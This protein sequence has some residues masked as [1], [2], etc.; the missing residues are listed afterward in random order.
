MSQSTQHTSFFAVATRPV[1][2][3]LVVVA[4]MIFAMVVLGGVTRLT[5]SGLSIVEWNPVMGAIPPLSERQWQTEFAKYQ[6][7]PEYRQVNVGMS[8]DAFKRIYWVEWLHRL[9]GRL[10]GLVFFVPLVYFAV[11]RKIPTSLVPKLAGLFVLGGLQGALGWFMVKS[12]LVHDPHV[13]P[14]RLTAHLGVAV[15]IYAFV[16]WIALGLRRPHSVAIREPMLRGFGWFVTALIYVMI[17]AGGLVAGTKAGFAFNTFPLMNGHLFPPGLYAM[18]PAWINVFE[19]IATVQ[20]DHRLIA[21]LLVLIV[22]AYWWMAR[23]ANLPAS[24]RQVFH[25]L[26]IALLVQVALG[27][28]TLLLIVPVWLGALHQAGALAVLTVALRLNHDLRSDT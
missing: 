25:L 10:I 8:L 1:A 3:W 14:Y 20:F 15:A 6:L 5:R 9:V 12:G 28:S 18:Q 19:N 11:R 27:I 21:Y 23:S 4:T 26:P 22:A 24:T 13:S 17:L 2:L 16:V 7:T